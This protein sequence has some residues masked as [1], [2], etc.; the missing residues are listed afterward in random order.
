MS[1]AKYTLIKSKFEGGIQFK[2]AFVYGIEIKTDSMKS[3][4]NTVITDISCNKNDVLKLISLLGDE[5]I[6]YTQLMY[7]IEDFII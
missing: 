7:I 1:K 5:D 2:D 3:E 6:E 4:P